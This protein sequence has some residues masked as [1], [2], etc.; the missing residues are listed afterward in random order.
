[1]ISKKESIDFCLDKLKFSR[2]N[3]INAIFTSKSIDD[4]EADFYVV[5]ERFGSGANN[6]GVRLGRE[7]AIQ[8]SNFLKNPI[9]HLLF[10]V[11]VRMR[12]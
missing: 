11:F 6:I 12:H 1:M 5:K 7:E 10:W 3:G 2:I 9:F 4:I 8:K